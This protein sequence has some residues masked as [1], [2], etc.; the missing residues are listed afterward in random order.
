MRNRAGCGGVPCRTVQEIPDLGEIE[1]LIPDSD[2]DPRFAGAVTT[3]CRIG[4]VLNGK[5]AS[6]HVGAGDETFQRGVVGMVDAC[7]QAARPMPP[8]WVKPNPA[9]YFRP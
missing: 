6:R 4:Q 5:I 1:N 2:A 3:E 7:H 8:R 9:S